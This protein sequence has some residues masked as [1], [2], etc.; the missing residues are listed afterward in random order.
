MNSVR[1]RPLLCGTAVVPTTSSN[2]SKQGTSVDDGDGGDAPGRI[3]ARGRS[4]GGRKVV[5]SNPPAPIG[6]QALGR[7]AV[8]VTPK[9]EP[10]SRERHL[11]SNGPESIGPTERRLPPLVLGG[12]AG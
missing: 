10:A 9:R 12:P 8:A 6:R 2:T 4:A 11:A 5:G 3:D 1:G 7:V